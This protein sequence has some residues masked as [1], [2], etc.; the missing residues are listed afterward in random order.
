MNF[1]KGLILFFGVE[2]FKMI[3]GINKNLTVQKNSYLK[4]CADV[5]NLGDE[6]FDQAT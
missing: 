6:L 3:S 5:K 2:E 1:V 4:W